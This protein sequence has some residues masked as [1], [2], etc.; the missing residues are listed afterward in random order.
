MSKQV[1]KNE[2]QPTELFDFSILNSLSEREAR[3]LLHKL[4]WQMS[5]LVFLIKNSITD[6]K[7][8]RLGKFS[9]GA[10]DLTR[11]EAAEVVLKLQRWLKQPK[12]LPNLSASEISNLCRFV[13]TIESPGSGRKPRSTNENLIEL[14]NKLTSK[15]EKRGVLKEIGFLVDKTPKDYGFKKRPSPSAL[16]KALR[17]ARRR[18]N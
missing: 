4:W 16:K 7:H 8:K 13:G 5:L 1:E 17:D 15:G 12:S 10:R 11:Q 9:K 14:Y 6:E 3:E 2:A 18:S